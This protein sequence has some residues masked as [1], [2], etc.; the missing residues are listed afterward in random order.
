M[1]GAEGFEPPITG[2]KPVALPLGHAPNENSCQ[3]I[4]NYSQLFFEI[5]STL[6]RL[7]EFGLHQVP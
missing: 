6:H 4:L 2:P 3:K 7:R 5:Y 1:A